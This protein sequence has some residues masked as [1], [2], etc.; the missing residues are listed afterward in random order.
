MARYI[1]NFVPDTQNHISGLS[2]KMP[3][4]G[5]IY[6]TLKHLESHKNN[7]VPK[8]LSAGECRDVLWF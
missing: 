5:R 7:L 3:K 1:I 8:E 4:E 6:L 2:F